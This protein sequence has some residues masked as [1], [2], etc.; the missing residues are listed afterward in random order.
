MSTGITANATIIRN[1]FIENDA[2][3]GSAIQ[4]EARDKTKMRSTIN[5]NVFYKNSQKRAS[6]S[7][8]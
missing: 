2:Y 4:V 1:I 5:Y 7:I 3:E 8:I 6:I